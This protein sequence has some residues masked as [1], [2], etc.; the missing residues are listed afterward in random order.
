MAL[1]RSLRHFDILDV[2]EGDGRLMNHP[3][4]P[5]DPK[6]PVGQYVPRRVVPEMNAEIGDDI[7]RDQ[8][9]D[10]RD[11]QNDTH[12]RERQRHDE[13]EDERND[14]ARQEGHPE[15]EL[16]VAQIAW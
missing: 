1:Y 12:N 4:A 13:P 10:Q 3:D 16:Q 14:I 11:D 7:G 5:S 9:D 15:P 6:T 2:L 8:H